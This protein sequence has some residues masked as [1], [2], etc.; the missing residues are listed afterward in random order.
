VSSPGVDS[1]L[2]AQ[3]EAMLERV[4]EHRDRRIAEIRASTVRQ[5]E[6][7]LRSARAE[8]RRS[9]HQA[10]ARERARMTQGLRQA[11]ARA[12][13]QARQLAQSQTRILL[14]EMW[15]QIATALEARWRAASERSAWIAAALTE[16]SELLSGRPWTI[17]HPAG[18]TSED[19]R[20]A[21]QLAR[22]RGA[23]AL[24]WQL[25]P[26]LRAGLRVKTP[27]TCVDATGP[28]LLARRT[29]IEAA[30][31]DEYAA[32][33]TAAV[34]SPAAARAMPARSTPGGAP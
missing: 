21:E 14:E 17:E 11:Q 8:A 5:V 29:D 20:E 33:L 26:R 19:R 34:Q 3:V 6:Q 16:A 7:I 1:V 25:D 30:F 18:L 23:S 32:T 4:A 13:L 27:G 28:G 24:E 2:E 31:L 15:Q 10:V 9:V 12:E 22:Q